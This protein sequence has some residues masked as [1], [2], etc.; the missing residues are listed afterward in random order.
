MTPR[1]LVTTRGDDAHPLWS[2]HTA[3]CWKGQMSVCALMLLTL[4]SVFGV[5]GFEG[6]K[7]LL[8]PTLTSMLSSTIALYISLTYVGSSFW[9]IGWGGRGSVARQALDSR[10]LSHFRVRLA[11]RRWSCFSVVMIVSKILT[12]CFSFVWWSDLKAEQTFLVTVTD[13]IYIYM[14]KLQHLKCKSM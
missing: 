2:C 11:W 8:V 14:T 3:L 4:L 12:C 6:N 1:L 13:S 9:S 7:I 5:L 10:W